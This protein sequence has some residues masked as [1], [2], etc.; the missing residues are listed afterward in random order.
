MTIIFWAATTMP[1]VMTGIP[2]AFSASGITIPPSPL[3]LL[4]GPFTVPIVMSM[5]PL[6][7]FFLFLRSSLSLGLFSR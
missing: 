3:G 6:A 2:V 7:F 5:F 4:W 1:V